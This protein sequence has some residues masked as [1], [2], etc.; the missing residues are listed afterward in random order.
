MS[1]RVSGDLKRVVKVTMMAGN[2]DCPEKL[3]FCRKIDNNQIHKHLGSLQLTNALDFLM[4]C[5]GWLVTV[6]ACY[7]IDLCVDV[8][9]E[10]YSLSLLVRFDV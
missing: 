5:V 8:V 9:F 4:M 6:V 7:L 3:Q 1:E 2:I 10:C